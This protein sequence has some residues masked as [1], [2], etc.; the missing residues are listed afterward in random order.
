MT[1]ALESTDA[2]NKLEDLSGVQIQPGENPYKALIKACHDDAT[3]I[4]SL[5]STHRVTRNSQQRDKFLSSDFK[6]VLVD[7]FLLRL[8]NPDIEPGFTDPRNCLVFWA[9]PPE[10][11][12]K[13]ASHLQSLLKQAA[14]NI[15]LMPPHRMHLTTLEVTHSRTPDEIASLVEQIR[16]SVPALTNFTFAHRSRLVRPMLSYD[17]AAVA[18]SF[19]PAA[20]E[21][22]ASPAPASAPA[23]GGSDHEVDDAYTYHHLRRDVFDLARTAGVD[24]A[25]RYVVPSA[26]I[27]LGRYLGQED[28]ATPEQRERWTR[29]IDEVNAWLEREVWDRAEGPFVGEWIVGQEKGIDARSGCLWYGG[30]RTIMMGEGF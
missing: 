2:K 28:H 14:H 4:Q 12:L 11:I 8:E 15:W 5:Y 29:T 10:H 24:V 16:P 13:L 19:V 18:V 22:V 7:P 23:A 6:E 27:T 25:S 30:G 3:E 9:R 17:L 21:P 20:G 26:H 1:P